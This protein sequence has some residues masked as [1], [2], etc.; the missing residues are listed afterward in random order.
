MA[1]TCQG[2]GGG[3]R[4]SRILAIIVSAPCV[5]CGNRPDWGGI[6]GYSRRQNLAPEGEFRGRNA[7][8][9]RIVP[10]F[11]HDFKELQLWLI[12]AQKRG[13]TMWHPFGS[14]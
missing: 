7:D 1:L 14:N 6:A 9:A 4:K 11:N 2:L 5:I 8:Q 13:A 3:K 12:A 10:N